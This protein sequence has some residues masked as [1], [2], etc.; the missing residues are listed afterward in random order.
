MLAL[1]WDVDVF[2][3]NCVGGLMVVV[4]RG[5]AL[6][7]EKKFLKLKSDFSVCVWGAVFVSVW[8]LWFC[9]RKFSV[10]MYVG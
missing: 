10:R 9:F 3:S 7:A 1:M 2:V 5:C 4:G 8:C 6:S